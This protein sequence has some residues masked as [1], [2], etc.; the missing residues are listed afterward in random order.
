[1]EWGAGDVF[2]APLDHEN[3]VTSVQ[4]GV[5]DIVVLVAQMLDQYF[6]TR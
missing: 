6:F 2:V 1:M 5:G 4:N 3:V